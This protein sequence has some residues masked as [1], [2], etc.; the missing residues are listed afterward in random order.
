[1][2]SEI[3]LAVSSADCPILNAC[4][5]S[6][7]ST[8]V[9][10]GESGAVCSAAIFAGTVVDCSTKRFSLSGYGV[11]HVPGEAEPLR[12]AVH[13]RSSEDGGGADGPA[14][15]PVHAGARQR[16]GAGV[17]DRAVGGR[18]R[19]ENLGGHREGLRAVDHELMPQRRKRWRY[20]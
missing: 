19:Q 12:R 14:L 16:A 9:N 3:L 2:P 8:C 4:S 1:M 10:R 17:Q 15:A 5:S 20:S 7:P 18:D 13:H 11:L 6:L